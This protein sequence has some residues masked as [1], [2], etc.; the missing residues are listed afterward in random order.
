MDKLAYTAYMPALGEEPSY[1]EVLASAKAALNKE[2]AMS[3]LLY[4]DHQTE[5]SFSGIRA[6]GWM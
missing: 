4:K 5:R 3:M 6:I 2:E 1:A